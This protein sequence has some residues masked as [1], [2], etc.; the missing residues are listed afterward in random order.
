MA[1]DEFFARWARRKSDAPRDPA[2]ASD[3]D[4]STPVTRTVADASQIDDSKARPLPSLEDVANLGHDSD[5]SVFMASGVDEA[6]K[7]SA[8]KKLFTNPHFN[9]MDGLDIYIDDYN[10]FE[11]ITPEILAALNHAKA[12]LN[13]LAQFEAPLMGLLDNLAEEPSENRME[14]EKTAPESGEQIAEIADQAQLPKHTL[15][16]TASKEIPPV[17]QDA[18][19]EAGVKSDQED[20]SQAS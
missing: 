17:E 6:V 16:Q 14:Q 20:S 2:P 7:R 4:A 3:A 12:L 15:S 11:P 10:K 1:A 8:M 18:G 19:A 9:I 5:Y 13:P